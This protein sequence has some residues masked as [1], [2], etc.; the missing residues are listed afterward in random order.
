MSR[1]EA[2]RPAFEARMVPRQKR[3]DVLVEQIKHWIVSN[4]M[5]PGD[6]LP[7][8]KELIDKLGMSRGTVREAL[9]ALEFQ[10]L[11]E[12][13]AG[14]SGGARVASM[15]L[16]HASQM[17][18]NYF[19]FRSPSWAEVYEMREMLE[20]TVAAAAVG[21]LTAEQ[22]E[23]LEASIETCRRGGTSDAEVRTIRSAELEFHRIIV[24]ACPNPLLRFQCHFIN[25]LLADFAE[26]RD[27]I[28]PDGE[29]FRQENLEA[30][31]ELIAALRQED[32][33]DVEALM[34]SHI[35]TAGCFVSEREDRVQRSLLL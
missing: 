8:E 2:E 11:I 5:Q 1:A 18:R 15:S 7:R 26:Y 33:G 28:Q 32:R 4:A 23:R 34:R 31:I 16:Q 19:Y 12:V 21:R 10:G 24:E 17:L 29:Q 27:V 30:H 22:F 20:P 9:R 35:H 14:A 13:T 25:D 3:A 6:E